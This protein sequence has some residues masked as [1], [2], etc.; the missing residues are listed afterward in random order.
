MLVVV[1]IIGLLVSLGI[2]AFRDAQKKARDSK[3]VGDVRLTI[4][5]FIS[6][7]NEGKSLC[8][9]NAGACGAAIGGSNVKLS[10][11]RLCDA[12]SGGT[13]RTVDYANITSL[14]DPLASGAAACV[15][16]GTNC[17]YGIKANST[18]G[19][20]EIYFYTEAPAPS[21]NTVGAH[22][23]NKHGIFQ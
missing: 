16:G 21:L 10:T 22:S 20:F 4:S 1:A 15:S 23:A 12:C 13:D 19:D 3:R 18:I 2:A 5:S 7:D 9:D 8:L 6:A 17:D 11:V 14:K